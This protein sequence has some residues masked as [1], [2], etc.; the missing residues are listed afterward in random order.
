MFDFFENKTKIFRIGKT[1]HKGNLINAQRA[2]N[3]QIGCIIDSQELQVLNRG[4]L[5]H[6]KEMPTELGV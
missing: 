5:I 2:V 3:Q 4:C 1:G 6:I